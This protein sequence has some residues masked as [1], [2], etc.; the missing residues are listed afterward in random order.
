MAT[1][2]GTLGRIPYAAAGT[3]LILVKYALDRALASAFDRSWSY[4]DYWSPSSL[5]IDELPASERGFYAALVALALPFA[6]VGLS[7]TVRRLRDARLPLWAV[8][9]FFVPVVN[10]LFFVVLSLAPSRREAS[11][12]RSGA[13]GCAAPRRASGARWPA[14]QRLPALPSGR[15]PPHAAARWPHAAARHH[16]VREPDVARALLACVV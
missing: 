8:L 13:P 2:T 14:P 16:L 12:R 3:V 1:W 5:P 6:A 4:Y 15:V 11:P 9:L 10:L 7:L